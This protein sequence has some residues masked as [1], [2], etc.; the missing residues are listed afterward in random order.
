MDVLL[1]VFDLNEFFYQVVQILA[2]L[3]GMSMLLMVGAPSLP[4]S[5]SQIC[6]DRLW[7]SEF[8]QLLN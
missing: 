8:V 2:L 5:P 1:K 7:P 4:V 6:L 3:Y